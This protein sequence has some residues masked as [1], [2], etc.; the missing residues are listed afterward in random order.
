MPVAFG[1][2]MIFAVL[3]R[4]C[5]IRCLRSYARLISFM[6]YYTTKL[7]IAKS[8]L[9][10]RSQKRDVCFPLITIVKKR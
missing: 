7:K 9:F 5:E 6:N 2:G 1:E 3:V 4:K 10:L 8:S